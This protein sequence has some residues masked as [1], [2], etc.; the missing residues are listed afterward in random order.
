MKRIAALALVAVG[1]LAAVPAVS[2]A[3]SDVKGPSCLDIIGGGFT[4]TS[5]GVNGYIE[6]AAPSCKQFTYTLYVTKTNGDLLSAVAPV[7]NQVSS[8]IVGFST[9]VPT[10]ETSVCVYATTSPMGGNFVFDRAPDAGV[11]DASGCPD[12]S[13]AVPKDGSPGF[14]GFH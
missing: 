9:T 10:T 7:P 3:A 14:G 8:M 11:I 4:Y 1:V 2:G 5:A 12:G 13:I 6:L